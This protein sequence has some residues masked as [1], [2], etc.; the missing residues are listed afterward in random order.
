MSEAADRARFQGNALLC[1]SRFGIVFSNA[2]QTGRDFAM[3][4]KSTRSDAVMGH[5]LAS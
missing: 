2:D 1:I 5:L 4:G 3:P